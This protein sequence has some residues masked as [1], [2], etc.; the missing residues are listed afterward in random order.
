MNQ[1]FYGLLEN[2]SKKGSLEF[3]LDFPLFKACSFKIGGPCAVAIYPKNEEALAFAVNTC[4]DNDIKY[5]VIGNGSNVLFSDKGYNGAVI[6]TSQMTAI[7]FD[8][9]TVTV[10]CGHSLTR[11]SSIARDRGLCGLQFAYGIPGSVGGAVY[12][13]AGAFGGEM[14]D[15]VT[16]VR[17]FDPKT[18]RFGEYRSD[19]LD[20]SY[21][22]SIFEHEDKIIVSA[23]I[24]L[25]QGE[26]EAIKAEMDDIMARRRDKQPLEYPSAGS[27][28]KRYPGYFTAKLIDDAGL[29]GYSVGGAQVSEKHAGFVINKDNATC[30]DVL[31]LV[32][33]IKKRIYEL[34][35][36][37]IECE[38]RIIPYE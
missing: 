21:R 8:G 34:N 25:S 35:G 17:Y 32:S 15:V 28:F 19:E 38:V 33:L 26:H 10:G 3:C 11:L 2:E 9:D 20:F 36:I 27:T 14:K 1:E 7:E 16:S 18:R 31:G 37:N 12:M 4:T 13:N 23:K 5:L 29:K 6:F 30:E 22:H 24:K